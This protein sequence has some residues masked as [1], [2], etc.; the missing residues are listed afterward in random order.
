MKQNDGFGSHGIYFVNDVRQCRE[1]LESGNFIIQEYLD[2][3]P[4]TATVQCCSVGKSCFDYSG[5]RISGSATADIKKY[6]LQDSGNLLV[7]KLS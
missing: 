4:D 6:E 5:K 7:I 2:P 1:F 3:D